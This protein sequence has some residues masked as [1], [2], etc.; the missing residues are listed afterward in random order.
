MKQ[1]TKAELRNQIKILQRK[2]LM[3]EAS[4]KLAKEEYRRLESYFNPMREKLLYAQI[5]VIGLLLTLA[6]IV[7][8]EFGL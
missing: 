3:E 8:M 1:P 2:L 7:F 5:A 4:T 6:A